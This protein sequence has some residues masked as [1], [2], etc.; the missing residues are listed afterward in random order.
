MNVTIRK[1]SIRD[2]KEVVA[3]W[4]SIPGLGVHLADA[5]SRDS[6]KSYLV[7]NPGMCFVACHKDNLVGA[8]LCGH[9]GRRG[10]LYHLTV[11]PKYRL[12]GIGRKLANHCLKA[13]AKAGIDKCYI[14]VFSTNIKA[15][16]FWK[17][18]GWSR[19][20]GLDPMC[21]FI[22]PSPVIKHKQHR[23][24]GPPLGVMHNFPI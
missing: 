20:E 9:D 4:T 1:M 12:Q 2:Y 5:D 7:R 10:V 16:Q 13:L 14:F 3:L 6:I 19:Y 11:D 18:I 17:K 22:K 8:V 24:A 23:T 15:K 21:R